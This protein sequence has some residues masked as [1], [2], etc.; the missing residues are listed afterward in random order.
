MTTLS[1]DKVYARN[2]RSTFGLNVKNLSKQVTSPKSHL[3]P[4]S[5][6]RVTVI[7]PENYKDD[8]LVNSSQIVDKSL[9]KR[10]TLMQA[11]ANYK[12]PSTSSLGTNMPRR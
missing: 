4:N 5:K 12:R 8:D 7:A 9:E 1:T 2:K 10:T 6:F 11:L 3:K